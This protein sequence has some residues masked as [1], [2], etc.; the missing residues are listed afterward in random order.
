V[1]PPAD[2]PPLSQPSPVAFPCQTDAQ[3]ILHRC[4]VQAGKCA[5]PCQTN[6][7]CQPGFQC[8]SP[9]CAPIPPTQ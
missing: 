2:S 7:D 5:F 4:N 3:C 6:N 8:I 1:A 9:A